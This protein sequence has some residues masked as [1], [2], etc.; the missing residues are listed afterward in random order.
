MEEAYVIGNNKCE[1]VTTVIDKRI[2]KFVLEI[3]WS[4]IIQLTNGISIQHFFL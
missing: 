2:I 3:Y 4:Q 1:H